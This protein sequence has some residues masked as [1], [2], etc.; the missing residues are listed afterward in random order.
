M[1]GFGA[2]EGGAA[3]L[4]MT[5]ALMLGMVVAPRLMARVGA[6]PMVVAGL[7]VLGAGLVGLSLARPDGNFAVDV[8]PASVVAAVGMAPASIP[9]L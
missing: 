2:F 6:K 5:L 7:V 8:L 3:L 4:P 1:L 9:S